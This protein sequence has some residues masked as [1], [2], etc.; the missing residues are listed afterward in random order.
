MLFDKSAWHQQSEHGLCKFLNMGKS[1]GFQADM[2]ISLFGRN[3]CAYPVRHRFID[4]F[5]LF[6]SIPRTLERD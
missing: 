5:H 3:A 1:S 2:Y 4:K 6:Q